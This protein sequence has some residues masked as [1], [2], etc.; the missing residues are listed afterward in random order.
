VSRALGLP[1]VA[2]RLLFGRPRA[3][4][5]SFAELREAYRER[6]RQGVTAGRFAPPP[7]AWDDPEAGRRRVIGH[8]REAG[9][10]LDRAA[11][12]WSG[13]EPALDR[14]ALPHPAL[15]RLSVREMLFFT[16]YHEAHHLRL[17]AE[18]RNGAP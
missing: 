10:E 12:G 3:P 14:L 5:R 17:V 7:R 18:R 8:W 16:L 15:G 9:R 11:A 13:R 1:R 4:S 2:L 6:L